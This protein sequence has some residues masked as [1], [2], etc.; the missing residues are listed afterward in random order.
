MPSETGVDRPVQP[1]RTER[2]VRAA[3]VVATAWRLVEAE[4]V[5]ALT[6]R[7]LGD[8][9][10]IKA[11]SLDKHV[12][13]KGSLEAALIEGALVEMGTALHAAVARPGRRGP[14]DALLA[15][16]RRQGLDHPNLYRLATAGELPRDELPPG[17][18]DWAGEPFLLVTGDAHRAQALWSFA[19][20]MV[21]LE[22]D[23]RFPAGSDLDRTWLAGAAAFSGAVATGRGC[24]PPAIRR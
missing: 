16:Y 3:Q 10:G 19:H 12:L 1:A 17:L 6:M 2:S 9:L 7:R 18:E 21:I 4:G 15:A 5:Q 24:R 23:D 22:I 14:V 11:P 8:E 13:D 20:G